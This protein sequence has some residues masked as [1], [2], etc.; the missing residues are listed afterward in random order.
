MEPRIR[1]GRMMAADE[2]RNDS[3]SQW[4]MSRNIKESEVTIDV[5]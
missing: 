3:V 4:Q 1:G 2:R 5:R